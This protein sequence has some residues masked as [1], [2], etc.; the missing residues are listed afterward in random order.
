M[1]NAGDK[2]RGQALLFGDL[3]VVRRYGEAHHEDWA[4]VRFRNE[5][6][7]MLVA[8]FSRDVDSHRHAL[9]GLVEHA[10]LLLVEDLPMSLAQL[11]ALREEVMAT[12]GTGAIVGIGPGWG[13]LH[14]RLGADQEDLATKLLDR[15]G[16]SV[17]LEVGVFKYP[18]PAGESL[19][20][21]GRSRYQQISIEGLEA[22]LHLDARTVPAGHRGRATVVLH[23]TGTGRAGPFHCGQPLV[24]RL[25]DEHGRQV[26]GLGKVGIAGTGLVIDLG[27][28]ERL[29]VAVVYGTASLRSDWGYLVPPGRYWVTTEVPF[30]RTL[31]G[32][33]SQALS[34][35]AEGL[36][37]VTQDRGGRA[38]TEIP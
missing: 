38:P 23:Y 33:P 37:V 26:G 9:A 22:R 21:V 19:P 31:P 24:G 32:V 30:Q 4:G 36:T 14:V 25:L 2:Q 12:V 29:K 27:P 8:A 6:S 28:D 1:D 16:D 20:P 5:P 3:G 13:R 35:P 7:V 34:V 18:M 10:D 15:Y 17:E 11:E